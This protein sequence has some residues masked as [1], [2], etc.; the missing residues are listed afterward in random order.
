MWRTPSYTVATKNH[1]LTLL[2]LC[3]G[4]GAGNAQAASPGS[5][6]AWG[7]NGFGQTNVPIAAQTL[8]TAVA[9]GTFHT[10]ALKNDGSVLAWGYNNDGQTTVPIVAQSGVTAIA[11][12]E[13]HTVALKNDG[14]VLAWGWNNNGQTNVP[15]AAQSGVM[16]IAAGYGHTVA[17][18]T[19][20]SIVAWGY[21]NDGQTT[22]PIAAQSGVTAI[23]AGYG[24]SVALKNDGSVVAWGFNSSGQVTGTPTTGAPYS[25]TASPVTI[26]GQVLTG[27]M[28]I[29]AGSYHS[30]ALKNDGSV[31]VWGWNNHGQTNVP[32]AAQSGVTAI[33]GGGFHVV[34][35]KN[36]GSVVV[37][38]STNNGQTT[39]PMV[40]QN[41]VTAIAAS[42]EHTVVVLTPS[43]P[44]IITQPISQTVNAGQSASFTVAATGLY[45]SYQ[46]RKDGTN[47]SGATGTTYNLGLAQT[48]RAGSYTVVVSNAGGSVTSAPPAILTVNQLAQAITFGAL[49]TKRVDSA[50]FNLSATASSGLPVSYTSS[51]SLV[52][53]ISGSLV[54]I[55]GIGSSTLTASQK[56]NAT[57]LPASSVSQT[58]TV[59]GIPPHIATQPVSR[60]VRVGQSV[61]FSVTATGS[62]PL[63]YRWSKN[64]TDIPNATNVSYVIPA[65]ADSD[66]G[67]YSVV[68]TNSAG[69]VTSSNVWLTVLDSPIFTTQPLSQTAGVGSNVTL[70]ATA[71]GAQPLVFQWY[72]KNSPVGSP[73]SGTNVAFYALTN[74]QTNNSGNYSVQVF[75]GYGSATSS[76]AVFSVVVFPP[77]ITMQPSNQSAAL[78]ESATFT[79]VVSGTPPFRY[80]WR[81]NANNIFDATNA[82]YTIPAVVES[83]A[84]NYSVV[85]SN[86]A[87]SVI[88]ANAALMV[89]GPPR[90]GLQILSGY[91]L[92]RLNGTLG[93]NFTVQY[94]T[95]LS[96]TNWLHL[97]SISN[98]SVNPYQFLDPAGSSDPARFYRAVMR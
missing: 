40:A 91:P 16:A 32:V 7:A 53:T 58:L 86:S 96:A 61:S 36:D 4:F 30:I 25:A 34:A 92:L 68:V 35:L 47:L 64:G 76:T 80:Q 17:L 74:V 11:A 63:I 23:A 45:L 60:T 42:Y 57:Y 51:D 84:G 29:A 54:T 98:L 65:V 18:K 66:A 46:W 26:G 21:N 72:F 41:G 10:A 56:G 75:N 22:I 50:P 49:A 13:R 71:Y 52:A 1:L 43:A 27:V 15:V 95:N 14:S 94:S 69:S 6:V 8:V 62:A 48:N 90:L 70:S 82:A 31:V 33:A 83:S 20:G 19:N 2:L 88:S 44:A 59:T 67:N 93:S 73:V 12:G 28:A 97:R 55:T 87:G 5:V 85:V 78:G 3:A 38:G 9:A 39:V 79:V 24:H 89:I 77:S 37:W 81:F